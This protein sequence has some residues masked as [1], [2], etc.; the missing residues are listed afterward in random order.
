MAMFQYEGARN[1]FEEETIV[2]HSKA[3]QKYAI[4][5]GSWYLIMKNLD[6]KYF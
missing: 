1:D 5:D 6:I 4:T 2:C 3:N